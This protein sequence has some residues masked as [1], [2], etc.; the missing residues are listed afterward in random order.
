[1]LTIE[2]NT[3][4]PV[5]DG[6]AERACD[7]LAADAV[8]VVAETAEEHAVALMQAYFRD[9]TPYYWLQVTIAHPAYLTSVVHDQGVV[10]GPWLEGVGERNKTSRFKGYWHWRQSRQAIAARVPELVEMVVSSRV[11]EMRG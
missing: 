1:M 9:P 11:A 4:G 5:F 2:I 7:E 8:D 3:S 10:Y 6:R